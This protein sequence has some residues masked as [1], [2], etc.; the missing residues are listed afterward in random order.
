MA[1]K[2]HT[3]EGFHYKYK[4]DGLGYNKIT[5]D[6]CFYIPPEQCIAPGFTYI[7]SGVF[8]EPKHAK[9]LDLHQIDRISSQLDAYSIEPPIL[10]ID[11]NNEVVFIF[12][13]RSEYTFEIIHPIY[14][15]VGLIDL[16]SM[17]IFNID[18]YDDSDTSE[19][20]PDNFSIEWLFK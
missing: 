17:Y 7:N 14:V 12:Y 20:S 3:I 15:V 16:D 11:K 8:V 10:D 4:E 1:L 6:L 9:R 2:E 19:D 13:N 5:M 18:G